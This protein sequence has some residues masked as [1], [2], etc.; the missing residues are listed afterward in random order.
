MTNL[1]PVLLAAFFAAL[2]PAAPRAQQD[3]DRAT[4]QRAREPDGTVGEGRAASFGGALAA[5]LADA[6]EAARGEAFARSPAM[7]SRLDVVAAAADARL[8]RGS[9]WVLTQLRGVVTSYEVTA[10]AAEPGGAVRVALRARVAGLEQPLPSMVV[11]LV[12]GGL[13]EWELR[14]FEEGGAGRAFARR[15][16]RFEGPPLSEYLRRS[17]GID[18]ARG[19]TAEL[20]PSHRVSVEWQ[21]AAVRSQV[22]KRNP[23]RPTNRARPEHLLGGTVALSLRIEDRSGGVKILDEAFRVAA[24][25][26]DQG[27][28][29]V[30]RLDAYVT[31]LVDKA[32]AEV[33][34]RIFF[35]LQPPLV[36]RK[37]VGGDGA[38]LVTVRM[39]KRVAGAYRTFSAGEPG[40]LAS[41][42]WQHLAAAELVGGTASTTTFRLGAPADPSR[43]VVGVTQVRPVR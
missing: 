42:D 36:L 16:G 35:A 40:S 37:W 2:T 8:E 38:W 14:R 27:D 26:R 5:A 18:V 23:A 33:A 43:L 9:G 17:G 30:D 21:P 32:K 6:V 4:A 13:S 41:P 25:D 15:S 28:W 11:E 1:V 7:Q 31:A 19:A 24:D 34:A 39:S 10:K 29:P 20:V 12:G 22:R 3:L